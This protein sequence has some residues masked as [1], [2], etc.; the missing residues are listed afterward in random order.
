MNNL[1]RR[2]KWDNLNRLET[3]RNEVSIPFEPLFRPFLYANVPYRRK[4]VGQF[5]VVFLVFI[6]L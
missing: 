5:P 2:K 6:M 4:K 3:A 1:Q